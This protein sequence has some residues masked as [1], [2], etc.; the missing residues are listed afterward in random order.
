MEN[1]KIKYSNKTLLDLKSNYTAAQNDLLFKKLVKSIGAPNEVAMKYTS[2][3]QDTVVELKR[4]E[5]CPNLLSCQNNIEGHVCYPNYKNNK[6][7]FAYT[8][9]RYQKQAITTNQVKGDNQILT[10][11]MADID[12]TDKKRVKVI[13]W[14]KNFY[15]EYSSGKT[16][17]GLFLHGNFGCGKTFLIAALFNELA[18]KRITTEIVYFP[19]LLREIKGDFDSYADRIEYLE[20]VDLLL[21]DDLGA[22]KVTEWGRDEI[23]GTILQYRMT[24]QKP[25]FFTSNLNLEDLEAHLAITSSSEDKVKA[26]RIIERIKQLTIDMEMISANRR[27]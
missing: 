13:K 9:C 5:N 22:E 26:R 4:C 8:P 11:K 20:E 2:Q 18:K 15:D 21:I 17:K 16:T 23:L 3:L 10:A 1:A 6:L 24:N 19:S 14:L 25:T 12:I 27:Q 7:I